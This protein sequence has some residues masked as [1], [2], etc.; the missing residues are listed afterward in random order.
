MVNALR[1]QKLSKPIWII[2]GSSALNMILGFAT[3]MVL[4]AQFGTGLE[5]DSYLAAT[6]IPTLVTLVL[7]SSLNVTLVPIFIEVETKKSSE[8]AWRLA[9]GIL[10]LSAVIFV[11]ITTIG[12]FAA[13][14]IIR[15]TTPGFIPGSSHFVLTTNLFKVLL[16]SI[17]FTGLAAILKSIYYAR[18]HFLQPSLTL[19]ANS[20][21]ILIGTVLLQNWLGIYSIAVSTLIGAFAQLLLLLPILFSQTN[22]NRY[23]LYFNLKDPAIGRALKVMLPWIA[24]ALIYKAN[25]LFDRFVASYLPTGSISI[26]AYALKLITALTTFIT[27]GISIA[28]FPLLSR[29]VAEN[30]EEGLCS[31]A[32]SGMRLIFYIV[33]PMAVGIIILNEP[34]VRILLQR[35]AFG[36]DATSSV[37]WAL[38][39][40]IGAFIITSVGTVLTRV[41]YA[42]Q[43]TLTVM[44]V[45]IVGAA[46]NFIGA[47]WLA[48]S[49]SYVGPA[50]AYSIAA[51]FNFAILYILLERRT[52]GFNSVALY[53]NLMQ[54]TIASC[55]MGGLIWL[56]MLYLQQYFI[57]GIVP[58]ILSISIISTVAGTFYLIL[59]YLMRIEEAHIVY[60]QFIS[61]IRRK[62]L[63]HSKL[64]A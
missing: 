34:L 25:P 45:S 16:P 28:I 58:Q 9:S 31:A 33:F 48:R 61:L 12:I 44:T 37:G 4:A 1:S 26:L 20:F 40:Y 51:I 23:S 15:F 14:Q 21:C 7:V 17:F 52:H 64:P 36:A 3:Q 13:P 35:G 47:L 19:P 29:Y 22:S 11:V 55:I 5:M 63:G 50:V 54:T 6:S 42:L 56:M 18:N 60:D 49:L 30:D 38:I 27:Q 8:D 46:I 2:T 41:Y 24:G 32:I 62:I 43:D 57:G 39:G 10:N 53:R 59:T